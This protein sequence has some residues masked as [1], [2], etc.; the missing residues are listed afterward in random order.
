MK[1]YNLGNEQRVKNE[2]VI[3]NTQL[4]QIK[5]VTQV[6]DATNMWCITKRQSSD[7][8]SY[9]CEDLSRCSSKAYRST[10]FL[11]KLSAEQEL[12]KIKNT[13]RGFKAFKIDTL[14]NHYINIWE[15]S[16]IGQELCLRNEL[17][18]INEYKTMMIKK[19][20]YY[21]RYPADIDDAISE[22]IKN[23][24]ERLENNT[25]EL[26]RL[27]DSIQKIK[28]AEKGLVDTIAHFGEIDELQ[29]LADKYTGSREKVVRM[30]HGAV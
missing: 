12:E 3:E 14:D 23:K 7:N 28:D 22:Y 10:I 25:K 17:L 21:M 8:Y 27:T 6:L 26:A 11:T 2:I 9:Y 4:G 24:K 16:T 15:F 29:H 13:R 5:I 1:L 18:G 19:R 30:L 20:P